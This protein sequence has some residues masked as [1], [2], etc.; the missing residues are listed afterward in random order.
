[1]ETLQSLLKDTNWLKL[2]EEELTLIVSP[3][4]RVKAKIDY[5]FSLFPLEWIALTQGKSGAT[6]FQR[7][8]SSYQASPPQATQVVDTVGAGDAFSSIL[9][10]GMVKGWDFPT[11]LTRGQEFASAIVGMQGATVKDE[12]F[13]TSFMDKWC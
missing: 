11:I 4:D 13:Y 10:L 1:M 7:S 8:G 9:L 2:N 3:K 12:S 5:L 6:L